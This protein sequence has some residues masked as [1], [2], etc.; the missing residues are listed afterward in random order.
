MGRFKDRVLAPTAILL[1]FSFVSFFQ[2]DSAESGK[3]TTG[4][5]HAFDLL[6]DG[7]FLTTDYLPDSIFIGQTEYDG[8]RSFFHPVLFG[9][10]AY[11]S[12]VAVAA[13][14]PGLNAAELVTPALN[15]C[16]LIFPFHSF[17]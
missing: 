16:T 2:P 5:S 12:Y 3:A 4:H 11:H 10:R 8:G 7:S 9:D 15:G 14:V 13:R 6:P 1:L 17:F